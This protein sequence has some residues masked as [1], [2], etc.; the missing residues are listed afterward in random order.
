MRLVR[1]GLLLLAMTPVCAYADC[2]IT[3]QIQKSAD[4][5]T[6]VTARPPSDADAKAIS[7]ENLALFMAPPTQDTCDKLDTLLVRAKALPPG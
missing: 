7:D 1:L 2:D 6:I 3:A 5:S 4:V